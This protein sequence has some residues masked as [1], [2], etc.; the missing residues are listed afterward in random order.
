MVTEGGRALMHVDESLAV[1]LHLD[2]AIGER[3]VN[4]NT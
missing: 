1:L 2:E 4:S 3:V